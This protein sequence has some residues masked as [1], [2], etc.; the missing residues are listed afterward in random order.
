MTGRAV[1]PRLVLLVQNGALSHAGITRILDCADIASVLAIGALP[2]QQVQAFQA[3]GIA[4]I[5]LDETDQPDA[6]GVMVTTSK[7]AHDIRKASGDSILGTGPAASRHE[8][9]LFGE[10][11][12]DFVL[13]AGHAPDKPL[14]TLTTVDTDLAAWWTDLMEVPGIAYAETVEDADRLAATG[15]EFLAVPQ[16]LW[17]SEDGSAALGVIAPH[18]ETTEQDT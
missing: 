15:I 17:T 2:H 1:L 6:D 14:T 12:P 8:A 13:L 18:H 4:V 7:A 3:A 11:Q 10:T 9:M 16:A 5:A